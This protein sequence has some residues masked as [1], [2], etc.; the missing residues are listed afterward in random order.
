MTLKEILV[1]LHNHAL[2]CDEQYENDKAIRLCN[3]IE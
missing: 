1:F 3:R 2:L